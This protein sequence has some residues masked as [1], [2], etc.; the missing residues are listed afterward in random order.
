[1]KK[2]FLLRQY[3]YTLPASALEIS[4]ISDR[5]PRLRHASGNLVEVSFDFEKGQLH[6]RGKWQRKKDD[7]KSEQ[8]PFCDTTLENFIISTEIFPQAIVALRE[9]SDQLFYLK[10]QVKGAGY[11][12]KCTGFLMIGCNRGSFPPSYGWRISVYL[13]EEEQEPTEIRFNVPV[14]AVLTED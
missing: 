12:T 7:N 6:V 8:Q 1:M 9:G 3:Q 13:Y 10:G 14:Y 4:G 2:H 11:K 5:T